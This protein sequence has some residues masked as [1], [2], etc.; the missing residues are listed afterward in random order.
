LVITIFII[1]EKTGGDASRLLIAFVFEYRRDDEACDDRPLCIKERI[2]NRIGNN[3]WK[4]FAYESQGGKQNEENGGKIPKNR[5][6][7][8]HGKVSFLY[9]LY[10][11]TY[12]IA[13]ISEVWLR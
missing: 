8:F 2:K 13:I 11:K 10:H 1:K 4:K 3:G 6:C 5:D 9:G 12:E 7:F